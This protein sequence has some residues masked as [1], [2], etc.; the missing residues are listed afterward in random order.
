MWKSCGLFLSD[1]VMR[2]GREGARH[3]NYFTLTSLTSKISAEF[4]G[5]DGR[6]AAPYAKSGGMCS[7]RLPPT[8]IPEIPSSQPL[9]TCP[10][11]SM[12]S[13]GGPPTELSIFLPLASQTV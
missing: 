5:T 2:R 10:A 3:T 6:P 1:Y 8:F 12:N 4:G 11:P 13:Y 9:M 7:W